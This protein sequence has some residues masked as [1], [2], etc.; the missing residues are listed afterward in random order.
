[1][2][3]AAR[4]TD[5]HEKHLFIGSCFTEHIGGCMAERKF[6]VDINPSGILYNPLSV[7]SLLDRLVSGEEWGEESLFFHDGLWHSFSHH[8]D[9]SAETREAALAMMN[10]RLRCSSAYL[11]EAGFL[12]L[13]LGSAWVYTLAD[14]GGVVANCHKLPASRF[15]RSLLSVKDVAERL[16]EALAGVWAVNPALQV[17]LTVS[18]VRHRADGA[19]GNQL[20]KATL[21]LAAHAVA[22]QA[23]THRCSYFPAYELVMDE[24]RD[25]RFYAADMVHLSESAVEFLWG[26]FE[27]WLI[28]EEEL[29]LSRQL[30]AIARAA[31]HR[32]C[33]PRTAEHLSFLR[34]TL[35]KTLELAKRHPAVDLSAEIDYFSKQL[36]EPGERPKPNEPFPGFPA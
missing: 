10:G 19:T 25:Y 9:F 35:R 11:R 29:A 31:R 5:Y 8:G 3:P 12:L 34:E 26:K 23:G 14:G 20:S 15:R 33:R 17:I 13:T 6:S 18:P 36:E 24:L 4:K 2:A 27:E 21:L 16:S 30:M 22:E 1:M 7:A 28:P 32:P